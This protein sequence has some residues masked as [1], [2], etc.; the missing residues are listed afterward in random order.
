[1]AQMDFFQRFLN[2]KRFSSNQRLPAF[3]C[4]ST[5]LDTPELNVVKYKPRQ[6]MTHEKYHNIPSKYMVGCPSNN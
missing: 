2:Q 4:L 5:Y 1:M 3:L 6:A